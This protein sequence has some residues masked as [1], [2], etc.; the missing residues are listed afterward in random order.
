MAI[1][2]AV[3]GGK[4]GVGKTTVAANLSY[5]LAGK[6]LRV[7]AVDLDTGLNCLNKVL[8]NPKPMFFLNDVLTGRCRVRQ[9]LVQNE[10]RQSCYSLSVR[11]K[12]EPHAQN[13]RALFARI[14]QMFDYILVD[15]PPG[16]GEDVERVLKCCDHAIVVFTPHPNAVRGAA[17]EIE[18]LE[19]Y[20][21]LKVYSVLNRVRGDLIKSGIIPTPFELFSMLKAVPLGLVPET[22]VFGYAAVGASDVF[23]IAANNLHNGKSD[24]FDCMRQYTGLFGKLKSKIKRNA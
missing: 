9:A 16:H 18:Y 13:I 2:I 19:P 15:C 21:Y 6:S 5:A 20:E 3:L 7:V 12:T 10:T 14:E 23:D 24:I 1:K 17:A 8:K 22:D 4:G 11:E